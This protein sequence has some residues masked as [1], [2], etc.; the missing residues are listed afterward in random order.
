[1][2]LVNDLIGQGRWDEA[3]SVLIRYAAQQPN[4][5]QV[6]YQLGTLCYNMVRFQEAEKH[7]RTALSVRQD[8]P[9]I[10]YHLGLALLKDNRPADAMACFR[11]TCEVKQ[12]YAVGHLHWGIALSAMGSYRGALGQ[13]NQA[14]KLNPQLVAAVYQAGVACFQLSQYQEAAQYFQTAT[15]LDPNLAEGFNGMGMTLVAIGKPAE[16]IP[17]FER[18][19]QLNNSLALAQR[20]WAQALVSLGQLDEAAR[21]YQEAVGQGNKALTARERALIYNDW[22]V[23]LFQQGRLEEGSEKLRYAVDVDPTLTDA[24]LNLG[25]IH[26]A[27]KEHD[28]AAD[29]FE[30]ALEV[31]PES[32]EIHFYLGI[33]YLFLGRYEQGLDRFAKAQGMG[34]TRPSVSLW[35]GY[36]QM[37]LGRTDVADLHFQRAA[38]EDSQNYLLFDAWGCCL[39][40]LGR[41]GEALDKY[42]YCLK[43]KQVN[44]LCHLHAAR[45]LE[46]LGRTEESKGEYRIAVKQDPACLNPEKECLEM[47][48]EASQYKL[49]LERSLRILDILPSDLDAQLVMARAFKAQ[50]RW[51]E[52]VSVLNS[53]LGEHSGNGEAHALLAHVYLAQAKL[54]EADEKFREASL[55]FEGDGQMFFAW[56]KTLT[57]LG[58]NEVALEK[59]RKASEIDPYDSDTYELWGETLKA[60]GRFQEATEVYKRASEYL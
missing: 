15:S 2:Q 1:M 12:G 10:H 47:L 23:N 24:K 53:I 40:L 43:L 37:A 34:Y 58:L 16:A 28:Q 6:E 48:M 41:H 14:M 19:C 17:Q 46:A 11:D 49:V 55:L 57:L 38:A 5:P 25:M 20:N 50:N 60:L 4:D 45:S 31:G 44:G 21:H 42:A 35:M 33:A 26:N 18:A 36:A 8:I 32:A 59:L 51:D 13:Y 9:D 3:H 39:A 27:L 7:L 22:G 54:T 56:G 52:C 29:A 30:K